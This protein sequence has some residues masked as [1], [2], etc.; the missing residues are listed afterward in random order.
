MLEFVGLNERAELVY[1]N[2]LSLGAAT[3]ADLGERLSLPTPLIRHAL[4][5]LEAAGLAAAS[6]SVADHYVAAPPGVALAP[7]LSQRRHELHEA[8][9]MVELLAEEYRRNGAAASGVADLVEV[10]TGI[11]AVRHR[12]EQIQLGTEEELLA[13][14][15]DAPV[16]VRP[17]ENAAEDI[18]VARGVIHRTVL[19]RASL[20]ESQVMAQMALAL[21]RGQQVRVADSVPTKLI[22][23]D[24]RMAMLPLRRLES[25]G[26]PAAL[27]VRAPGLL[28]ALIG[29][30]E[31][32]WRLAFPV[33]F[34]SDAGLPVEDVADQPDHV[35]LQIVS[36]LLAGLTDASV[37]KQLDLGLRTVQRRVQRLMMLTGVT[38]R[39]QLGWH[40]YEKGWVAR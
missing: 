4:A 25:P 1:R 12:F 29:L 10:V 39:M 23:A 18:V 36:L 7:A 38:T 22:I 8:E 35:D 11:S 40:A 15:T 34:S 16:A 31:Q 17:E 27:L 21:G 6:A 13:L 33:R 5:D 26:E 32:S 19:S 28:E 2:L 9:R 14:V 37:A 3:P 20:A 30:F 24:R